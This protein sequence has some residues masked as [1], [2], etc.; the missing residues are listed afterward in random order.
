L[1]GLRRKRKKTT[2]N[3]RRETPGGINK[4][5]GV[6]KQTLLKRSLGIGAPVL[7]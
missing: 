7:N 1:L 5:K 2:T 6:W 4:E 3:G